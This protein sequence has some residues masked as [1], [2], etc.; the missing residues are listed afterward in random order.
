MSAWNQLL[1]RLLE[2]GRGLCLGLGLLGMTAVAAADPVPPSAGWRRHTL[3][4][5]SRGADGVRLDDVNRDGLPDA[6]T[7]WEEG[8]LVRVYFHPGVERVRRE[9]PRVTVGQVAAPEDAV[10]VDLDGDAELDV[11]SCCEGRTRT[12]F[13]HWAPADPAQRG[14]DSAWTTAAIPCT[15]GR[16]MWM[17]ALPLP[18]G[19]GAHPMLIVGAKG[20]G[21]TISRLVPGG[22]PRDLSGWTLSPLCRAGWIMSL[23]AVDFD[24]DGDLDVLFSDRKGPTR[25]CHWLEQPDTGSQSAWPVHFIGGA[26]HEVMFLDHADLDGDGLRE[27]IAATSDAGLLIF[28]QEMPGAAW[29]ARHVPMPPETGTGKAVRGVDVDLDGQLELVVSCESAAGRH[30][31]FWLESAGTGPAGSVL[32]PISGRDEGVK[33]DRIEAVDLDQDGDQDVMT[34]EERDGLGVIWYENPHR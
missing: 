13:V 20:P 21:A 18:A 33:F 5:S 26:D 34:C 19:D 9:W 8:H 1:P 6:V 4:A 28:R 17:F 15:A 10:L 11:I 14:D 30:G 24:A 7:G 3:D 29:K 16:Q 22:N 32:Q 2:T 31:V 27:V 25:G 23:R 12:V